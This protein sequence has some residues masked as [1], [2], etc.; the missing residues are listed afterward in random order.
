[1]GKDKHTGPRPGRIETA[2]LCEA[3]GR[4]R[5]IAEAYGRV[6]AQVHGIT[7]EVKEN[8]V[9]KGRN[10]FE[11]QYKI[12]IRK[13]D[14]F[15]EA[16]LDIYDALVEAQAQYETADDALRKELVKAIRS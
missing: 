12:L 7:N 6:N 4:M 15:G 5:E 3:H 1:M 10:E 8:W 13:V 16:L 14:D 11:F 2:R 9:G